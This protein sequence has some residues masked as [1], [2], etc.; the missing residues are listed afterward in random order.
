VTKLLLA[1]LVPVVCFATGP[2]LVQHG[3][4]TTP[5]V[6]V[7]TTPKDTTGSALNVV[8]CINIVG[9]TI[10]AT[11]VVTDSS[12]NSYSA[13]SERTV[14]NLHIRTFYSPNPI[15]SI[16]Q[17]FTCTNTTTQFIVFYETFSG[18]GAMPY[19]VENGAAAT[20]PGGSAGTTF[21]GGA[22]LPSANNSVVVT[23]IGVGNAGFGSTLSTVSGFTVT[24][25]FA[26]GAGASG[27]GMAYQIQTTATSVNPAWASTNLSQPWAIANT[28]FGPSAASGPK[29]KSTNE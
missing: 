5:A 28:V 29:H 9:T 14:G 23:F 26:P 18:T 15:N 6:G 2:A 12:G 1:V 19:D 16:V 22:V 3:A 25:V 21:Q 27:G 8:G 17:T 7:V 11:G 24:D 10:P 4:N 20:A 13:R